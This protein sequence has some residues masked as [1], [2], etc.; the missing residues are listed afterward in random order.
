MTSKRKVMNNIK[1]EML[2]ADRKKIKKFVRGFLG[3]IKELEWK[4][5][6]FLYS[7]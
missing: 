6:G 3:E 1:K 7:L 2:D 4:I 5:R